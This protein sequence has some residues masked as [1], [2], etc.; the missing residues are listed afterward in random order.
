MNPHCRIGRVKPKSG[1]VTMLPGVDTSRE[2]EQALRRHAAQIAD[3]WPGH[4]GGFAIVAWAMDGRW[5]R[6][7]RINNK[8]FVGQ[9]L[10][11][12]Y[13]AEILRRDVAADVTREVLRGEA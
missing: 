1:N 12:A 5:A 7:T 8:S 6:G 9:T 11:P 13:V 10:L 2:I 4:M 3:Y